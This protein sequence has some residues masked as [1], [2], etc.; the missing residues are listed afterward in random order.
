M[1][2]D[3]IENWCKRRKISCTIRSD[4]SV[5][6]HVDALINTKMHKFPFKVN[7]CQGNFIVSDNGLHTLENFPEKVFQ[8]CNVSDNKLTTLEHCPKEIYGNFG[9]S[10]NPLETFKFLPDQVDGVLFCSNIPI[11]DPYEWRYFLFKDIKRLSTG[12][13]GNTKEDIIINIINKY[14]GK[15]DQFHIAIDELMNLGES[16]GFTYD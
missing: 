2:K 14:L 16:L 4:L 8:T 6:I 5:D 9:I 1:T 7:V 10:N 3:E 11:N 15:P 13:R 12:I